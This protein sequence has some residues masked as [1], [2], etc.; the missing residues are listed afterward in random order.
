M[1]RFLEGQLPAPGMAPCRRK[2]L[3]AAAER[4][5]TAPPTTGARRRRGLR[6]SIGAQITEDYR[7][8]VLERWRAKA[9]V[10]TVPGRRRKQSGDAGIAPGKS[11]PARVLSLQFIRDYTCVR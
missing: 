3:E 9:E 1:S 6:R 10:N 11:A 2:V 8:A 7:Q 5:H 4:P